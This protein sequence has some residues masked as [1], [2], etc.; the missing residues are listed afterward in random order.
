MGNPK[1]SFSTETAF[2]LSNPVTPVK[3]RIQNIR[4]KRDSRFRGKDRLAPLFS[5]PLEAS[6]FLCL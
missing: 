1:K 2:K 5:L 4:K 3:T 6:A